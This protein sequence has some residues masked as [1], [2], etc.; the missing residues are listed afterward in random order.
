MQ[1]TPP[2][3]PWPLY[4][5]EPLVFIGHG[6]QALGVARAAIEAAVELAKTKDGWGGV[7]MRDILRV[8]SV[9]VEAT[10]LQLAASCFPTVGGEAA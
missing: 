2:H 8:Q 7:K 6:T 3:H 5:T 1:V 9:I 10:A 4:Q